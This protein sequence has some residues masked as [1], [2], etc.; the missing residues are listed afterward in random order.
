MTAANVSRPYAP[1]Y[2]IPE[3]QEGILPWSHV[4]E[5]LREARNYWIVTVQPDGKPHA[6]P[7]G[8]AWHNGVLYFGGQR[9]ARWVRNL[10][11]N[12]HIVVHLESGDDVVILDGKC[13]KETDRLLVK[14]IDAVYYGSKY[15]GS[16]DESDEAGGWLALKPRTVLAW[17]AFPQNATRWEFEEPT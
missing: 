13:Y 16:P 9:R 5:R 6:V 7:I 8:G 4:E 14:Q 2:G 11:A 17:S 15:G 12:P 3:T 10:T 1:G